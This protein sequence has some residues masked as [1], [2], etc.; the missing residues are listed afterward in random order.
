MPNEISNDGLTP[1]EKIAAGLEQREQRRSGLR[2]PSHDHLKPKTVQQNSNFVVNVTLTLHR[3][4]KCGTFFANEHPQGLR[5]RD[6]ICA[7]C[8]EF[9]EFKMSGDLKILDMENTEFQKEVRSLKRQA[10]KAEKIL[11]RERYHRQISSLK[12]KSKKKK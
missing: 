2:P 6:T 4:S 7:K 5:L 8:Y 3:C 1:V 12:G 10:S 9:S 11:E